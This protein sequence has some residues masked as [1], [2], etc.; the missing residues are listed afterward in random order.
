MKT[1]KTIQELAAEITRQAESKHDYVATTEAMSIVA[2]FDQP[3]A[4]AEPVPS[5]SLRLGNKGRY[6][7]NDIAHD[8]IAEHVKVPKP[9]YDRM[10]RE[11]HGPDSRLPGSRFPVGQI[12]DRSRQH[13]L[14]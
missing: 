3:I 14:R 11:A 1:G 2:D 9:Y 4:G 7:L 8:Q 10:R 5:V 12:P 6:P 13:R